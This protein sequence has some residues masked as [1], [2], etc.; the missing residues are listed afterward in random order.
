MEGYIYVLINPAMPG[1]A[2]VGKTRRRPEDRG[3]ELSSATGV[4]SPFIVAYQHPVA[5]IDA[6]ERWVH[7]ELE[8]TGHRHSASREFFSAPLHVV[9]EVVS[10]AGLIRAPGLNRDASSDT[11]ADALT[12]EDLAERLYEMGEAAR[13]NFDQL[14]RP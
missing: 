11:T 14:I 13:P 1:L 4:P 7:G 9:V 5:D 12:G 8:R 3:L 6:A 2:K 10:R